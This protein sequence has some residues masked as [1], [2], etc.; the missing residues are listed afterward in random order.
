VRV[1]DEVLDAAAI[2]SE[3][4]L[5]E[6][7]EKLGNRLDNQVTH[8]LQIT[9]GFFTDIF[10]R[11][12]E[13]QLLQLPY[14]LAQVNVAEATKPLIISLEERYELQRKLEAIAPKLR[15]QLRR[16]AELMAVGR[17]QEMDGSCLRD[18]IRRPGRTAAEKAGSKQ[19][20]MGIQLLS[21]Q[22]RLHQ[23]KERE[24]AS[25]VISQSVTSRY[26]IY[27]LVSSTNPVSKC[28]CK[29]FI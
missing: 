6:W 11:P 19:E 3:E 12:S 14:K 10:G 13:I 25:L 17:I 8:L 28:G 1:A 23:K 18:Y 26:C 29:S 5:N 15:H 27:M 4:Q 7:S 22:S 21:S 2:E 24:R 9:L 20:L 16:Q